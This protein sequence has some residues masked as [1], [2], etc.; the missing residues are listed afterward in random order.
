MAKQSIAQPRCIALLKAKRFLKYPSLMAT[1]RMRWAE[2]IV[3]EFADINDCPI[4]VRQVHCHCPQCLRH[5]M[6][7]ICSGSSSGRGKLIYTSASVPVAWAI[8]RM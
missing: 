4:A 8:Q 1:A 2:A 6:A 5:A 3:L 7:V